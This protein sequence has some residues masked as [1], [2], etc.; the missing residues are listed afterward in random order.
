MDSMVLHVLG[1]LVNDLALNSW[2]YGESYK[3]A[4][5]LVPI[6]DGLANP[7]EGKQIVTFG[8]LG[9]FNFR[10]FFISGRL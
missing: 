3:V 1:V 7:V 10:L 2:F 9:I 4:L 8:W 5:E 6:G